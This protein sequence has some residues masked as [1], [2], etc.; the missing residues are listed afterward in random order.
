MPD[1]TVTISAS[2]S[3]NGLITLNGADRVSSTA[4]RTA[5]HHHEHLLPRQGAANQPGSD[6]ITVR[7]C[8]LC[9]REP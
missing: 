1:S 8:T 9:A 5:S 7:N 2:L 3:S 6:N 4:A